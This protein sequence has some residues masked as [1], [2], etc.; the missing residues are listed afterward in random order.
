MQLES[1]TYLRLN[2]QLS[3]YVRGTFHDVESTDT[4]TSHEGRY[5]PVLGKSTILYTDNSMQDNVS[6][7]DRITVVTC[8]SSDYVVG[9]NS[10]LNFLRILEV[11]ESRSRSFGHVPAHDS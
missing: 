3:K 10:V 1:C 11:S 2:E 5:N 7:L 9:M 4:G 8:V 6:S